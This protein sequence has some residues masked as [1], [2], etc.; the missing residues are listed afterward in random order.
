MIS[1]QKI[2]NLYLCLLPLMGQAEFR[3]KRFIT[4]NDVTLNVFIVYVDLYIILS[5]TWKK[6]RYIRPRQY[7]DLYIILSQTWKKR[8]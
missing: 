8:R 6:G 3:Q 4:P 2:M 7:V 1:I 5:H